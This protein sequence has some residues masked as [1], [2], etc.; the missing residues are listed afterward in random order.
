MIGIPDYRSEGV[1]LYARSNSRPVQH[2]DFIRLPSVRRRYWARNFVAWPQFS[3]IQP[4]ATHKGLARL[5]QNGPI[6]FLVTQNVDRLHTKA[7]SKNVLELHGCGYNV[8]CLHCDY[9]IDR[10]ELQHIFNTM[11]KKLMEQID[12]TRPDGDVD[13]PQVNDFVLILLNTFVS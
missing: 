3:N 5:E 13:I 7:G 8:I 10:H 1:G 11:N 4:N 9:S 6:K 12:L 2:L